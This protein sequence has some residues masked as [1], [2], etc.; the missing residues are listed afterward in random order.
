M[1]TRPVTISFLGDMFLGGEY[2]PYAKTR[3]YDLLY[4]FRDVQSWFHDPDILVVNLEGP[5]SGHGEKRSRVS[6]LLSNHPA[7]LGLVRGRSHVV[8]NL[9]NNHAMDQGPIGL[10]RTLRLIGESG[11]HSVGAGMNREA[12][13]AALFLEVNGMRIA[14]LSVTSEEPIVGSVI[15]GPDRPGCAS[16]FPPVRAVSRVHA[17]RKEADTLCV[18]LHWGHEYYGFPSPGQVLF[19]R[20]LVGAG[21]DLVIGHHPHVAQGLE[22]QKDGLIAYS[23]GN[24]FL[25]P[26]RMENGRIQTRK[27]SGREFMALNVTIEKGHPPGFEMLGG[28]VRQDYTL[29]PY[30]GPELIRFRERIER[31]SSPIQADDYDS[32][33]EKYREKRERVLARES[34]IEAA[35]RLFRQSPR[36]LLA[37]LSLEDVRRNWRRLVKAI[38]N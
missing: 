23:L 38:Q 28:K 4:V 14:F 16:M 13:E 21:A 34:F 31:L 10:E 9:G 20:E 7:V 33:W 29:N 37:T 3:G 15:A 17:A 18:I 1:M 11:Y 2:L 27:K 8:M 30:T 25:P 19:A 6:S 35:G 24:F 5:I 12:A 36:Q 26:V 22:R 32:Y